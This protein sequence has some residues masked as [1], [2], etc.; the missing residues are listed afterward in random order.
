M[1]S[2]KQAVLTT[3][4][5][6]DLFDFPLSPEELYRYLIAKQT[7]KRSDFAKALLQL[8]KEKRIVLKNGYYCLVGRG[9]IIPKRT[10]NLREVERKLRIAK[11]AAYYLSYIPTIQF[12]GISGG[13]SVGNVTK[14]DDIDFFI[15]ARAGTVYVTRLFVLFLLEIMGL[16]RKRNQST[17]ADTICVN[18]FLDETRLHFDR[19][20][21]DIYTAHEIVQLVPLF[22]RG[23]TYIN[24]LTKNI[25]V[26]KFMPHVFAKLS[27]NSFEKWRTNYYTL[28]T[29]SIILGISPIEKLFRIAQLISIKKHQTTETV[30]KHMLAFHPNNYRTKILRNLSKK[31]TELGLLTNF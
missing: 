21:Q 9:S 2:K 23:E 16:R 11:H 14:N 26:T 27:S 20:Y 17:A 12:I 19:V 7:V 5:Y 31:M 4:L 25:W 24:F 6:S 8:E 1:E 29:I 28:H 30:T 13:L 18:F 3:I 22:E 15:I 10:Q